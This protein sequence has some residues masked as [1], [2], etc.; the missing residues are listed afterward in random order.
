MSNVHSEKI[1]HAVSRLTDAGLGNNNQAASSTNSSSKG[2]SNTKWII[3]GSVLGGVGLLLLLV[4]AYFCVRRRR[5][6]RAYN[7]VHRGVDVP[8][9]PGGPGMSGGLMPVR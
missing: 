4:S 2:G 9:A 7:I 1:D 8:S 3:I 5:K 6:T